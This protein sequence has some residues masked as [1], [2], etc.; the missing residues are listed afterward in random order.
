ML[1][2]GASSTEPWNHV[3][4]IIVQAVAFSAAVSVCASPIA[5]QDSLN[6][7]RILPVE[8]GVA[9]VARVGGARFVSCAGGTC[10]CIGPDRSSS[11]MPTVPLTVSSERVVRQTAA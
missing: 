6:S 11:P 3:V 5:A 8:P 7:R 10:S 2:A 4:R 9:A 1:R